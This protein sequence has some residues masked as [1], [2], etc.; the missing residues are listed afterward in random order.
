M[1]DKKESPASAGLSF[2]SIL[3][4]ENGE[5]SRA[6]RKVLQQI[7]NLFKDLCRR[8]SGP[9]GTG[10]P[11]LFRA[12][13]LLGQGLGHLFLNGFGG[14]GR[15]GGLRNRPSHNK[16]ARTPSQSVGGRGDALLVAH[17]RP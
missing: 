2:L 11:E 13:K 14:V 3:S 6:P 5:L 8:A 15:V 9:E 4:C 17:G 10:S 12:G 16:V 1:Q 7:N